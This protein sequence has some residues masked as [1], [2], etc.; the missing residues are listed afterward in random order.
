MVLEYKYLGEQ[1]FVDGNNKVICKDKRVKEL[2]EELLEITLTQSET[3]EGLPPGF[4]NFPTVAFIAIHYQSK[5]E[6]QEE[7]SR[8]Y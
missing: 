8:I 3:H 7:N 1:I 6:E 2:F 5:A 4:K